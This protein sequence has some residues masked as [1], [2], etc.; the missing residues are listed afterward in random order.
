MKHTLAFLLLLGAAPLSAQINVSGTVNDKANEKLG[1]AI[2]KAWDAPGKGKKKEKKTSSDDAKNGTPSSSAAEG[3]APAK[4]D[5]AHKPAQSSLKSYQNYDFVPGE[6]IIFEDDF[7]ADMEGEFP[8][9]WELKYGQAVIG[10]A[11]GERAFLLTDG[12]Y[13]RVGP[14]MKTARYLDDPFTLEFDYYHLNSDEGHAYGIR[15][16]FPGESGEAAIDIDAEGV[17]YTSGD[18][19][20]KLY[21]AMPAEIQSIGRFSNRWHHIALAYKNRQLKIYVDQHRVLVVPDAKAVF[22]ALEFGGIA[23]EQ[24]PLVFKNVRL[25]EGGGMNMLGKILTE[26]KFV[27]RAITFDV[28]KASIKPESMGFLNELSKFLKE[29]PTVKLEIGGH[30]DSDGD[31]ASN[32]KLS[33][34]RAEAVRTQLQSMG[35][36]AA[37]LNAKG[38]GETKPADSNATPE[39]KANN[40]RVEFVKL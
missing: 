29:N 5:T 34:A 39:G 19:S 17:S 7:A 11:G 20:V 2:D 36:D 35:V 13:A 25:A 30:T 14:R 24:F 28:N 10:K 40:R 6:K 1:Q 23:G 8:A 27:T 4:S 12:N 18:G 32:M 3:A 31:D 33:Q 37:R 21:K 16:M 38:Y 22:S 9:H 26:G 15:L